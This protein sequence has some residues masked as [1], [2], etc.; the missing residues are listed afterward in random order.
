MERVQEGA[1]SQD[2]QLLYIQPRR[3]LRI[4][5]SQED[6]RAPS[7]QACRVLVMKGDNSV[8]LVRLVEVTFVIIY[9]SEYQESIHI[10]MININFINL[11]PSPSLT[12]R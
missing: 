12:F 10:Q 3:H 11:I 6:E 4:R 7:V 1:D 9:T 2:D 8:I 5:V